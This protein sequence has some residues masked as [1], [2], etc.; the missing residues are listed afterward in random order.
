MK[1]LETLKKTLANTDA[2]TL[3]AML[4][5]IAQ[6]EAV[7]LLENATNALKAREQLALLQFAELEKALKNA[8]YTLVLDVNFENCKAQEINLTRFS[9]IDA[10]NKRALH[11]YQHTDTFDICFS[12]SEAVRAKVEAVA[13]IRDALAVQYRAKVA[14][15]TVLKQIQ[16]DELV[17]ACK[18]ALLILENTLEDLQKFAEAEKQKQ[19]A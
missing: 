17:N 19:N 16:F 9:L 14:R 15:T 2:Q 13:E 10:H 7:T 5:A 1:K 18:F 11:L 6:N 12:C 8:K 4:K 3:D